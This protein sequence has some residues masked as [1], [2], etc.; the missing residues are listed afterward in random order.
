MKAAASFFF[1]LLGL[2]LGGLAANIALVGAEPA[3]PAPAESIEGEVLEGPTTRGPVGE[4]FLY[5]EVS[6]QDSD[7][8]QTSLGTIHWRG[9]FGSPR[10]RVRT[11]DGD[12]DV[13]LPDPARW[14]MLADAEESREVSSIDHLPIVGEVSIGDRLSPPFRVSVR[15]VRAGD[16]IIVAK[17]RGSRIPLYVGARAELEASRASR[18]VGRFPIV[19]IL[20]VLAISSVVL[21]VKLRRGS[22][23]DGREPGDDAAVSG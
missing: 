16:H 2:G 21:A 4:P 1:V 5:A 13:S 3:I 17:D 11:A 14:R 8:T 15:A 6:L 20:A 7:N 22:F 23:L 12:R 18:E 19:I 10:V 9:A